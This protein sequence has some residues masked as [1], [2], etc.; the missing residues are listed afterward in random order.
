[1]ALDYTLFNVFKGFNDYFTPNST[2]FL[3]YCLW[4]LE[5][6]F[7]TMKTCYNKRPE[8]LET[9][10]IHPWDITHVICVLDRPFDKDN[11]HFF[12]D[13]KVQIILTS[14]EDFETELNL[15]KEAGYKY[16]CVLYLPSEEIV[17]L[18]QVGEIM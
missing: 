15:C 11:P 12:E 13:V 6:N 1:M 10:R 2:M 18:E 5:R 16:G 4:F 17:P 8:M 7:N 3:D 14:E 9:P